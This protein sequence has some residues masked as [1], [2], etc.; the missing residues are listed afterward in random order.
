MISPKSIRCVVFSLL[1]ELVLK[2][3]APEIGRGEGVNGDMSMRRAFFVRAHSAAV[4][5]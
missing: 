4:R 1:A 5:E 2:P 3:G